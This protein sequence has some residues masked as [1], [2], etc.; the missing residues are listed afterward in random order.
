M[1]FSQLPHSER[2]REKL[3]K[4][5][6]DSLS[7]AELLAILLRTG[8][9]GEDVAALSQGLLRRMGGLAG[10]ARA[11]TAE[12]MQE[13]GLKEA[14]AASL[15]AALELGKRMVLMKGA[16]SSDWRGALLAKA[17]ETKYME[18]E[19]IFALFLS[20]KDR[21]LGESELSFGGISGAYLDL[22]V[23]FRQAVRIS[24][25]KVVVLHNHPDGCRLP[26]R[27]DVKLTEH[28]EQ[29]LRFLGMQLKGHYIAADGELFPV[30]GER[31]AE[32]GLEAAPGKI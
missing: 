24:A 10:L 26:S 23:F 28:I 12:M 31:L 22:P 14:K 16:E 17:F 6:P 27:D 21:V 7:L 32:Y 1:D 3:I 18:R 4:H 2:P 29:G 13:K 8:R 19:C 25:A 15:A 9:K 5:G 30:K 11:T 20:A